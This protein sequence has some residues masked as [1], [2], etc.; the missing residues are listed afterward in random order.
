MRPFHS[1]L[2]QLGASSWLPRVSEHSW[3]FP[4][5]PVYLEMKL[6]W[7]IFL[8]FFQENR[9]KVVSMT[10]ESFGEQ[11]TFLVSVFLVSSRGIRAFQ[12]IPRRF[13]G[14]FLGGSSQ[15]ASK[16]QKG[17]EGKRVCKRS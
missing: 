8:D 13:P 14:G 9:V 4:F 6:I 17:V 7:E 16:G 15:C 3:Q 12:G 1:S 10:R 2:T 5:P 11:K